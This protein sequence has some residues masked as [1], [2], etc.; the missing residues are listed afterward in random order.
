MNKNNLLIV[1]YCH[2][3]DGFLYG[4]EALKKYNYNI[5][6][7]PY[8]SYKMDKIELCRLFKQMNI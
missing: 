6:F 7:F 8:L 5:Y 4:A 1:G 3:A 2:L